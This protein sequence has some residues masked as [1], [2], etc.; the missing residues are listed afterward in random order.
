MKKPK[1]KY[2][3]KVKVI[4][5]FFEGQT[6]VIRDVLSFFGFGRRYKVYCDAVGPVVIKESNMTSLDFPNKEFNMKLQ[7]EIN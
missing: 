2:N 1:F 6:G 4:N 5:G 7:K 3:E